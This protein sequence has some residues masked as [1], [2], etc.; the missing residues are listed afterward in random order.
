MEG[1]RQV[2]AVLLPWLAQGHIN[3]FLNLSKALASHGAV[4]LWIVSTPVNIS[5]IRA[6]LQ[7]E[8]IQLIEL[9]LPSVEGLAHGIERT[10]DIK[11]ESAHLLHRAFDQLDKPFEDL[12]RHLSPDVVI[13]DLPA[14]C[15][16]TVSANLG[17]PTLVFDVYSPTASSFVRSHSMHATNHGTKTPQDLTQPVPGFPSPFI[18]W[19]L[20]EAKASA[21]MFLP[22]P[23]GF[24]VTD[25]MSSA[26][27]QSSGILIK[28]CFQ[29]EEKY[30]QYLRESTGKPVISVGPLMLT[31]AEADAGV[32][33]YSTLNWL[34]KQVISSVVFV[35]F[36]SESFL[37]AAQITELA[38]ALEDSG[39][40]FLW[41]LRSS[42]GTSSLSLS[43]LPAGFESRTRDRGLVMGGWVPQI[44]IV[45]HPSVGCYV[46]HGGW[47]SVM[48]AWLYSGLPLVLIPLR[49]DQGLNCR[50]I[51]LEL[52]GGIE[53]VRDEEGGFSRENVCKAIGMVMGKDERG[54]AIRSRV[55]ELQ[56]VIR[57]NNARQ[58]AITQDLVNYLRT[59]LV[60]K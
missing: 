18:S 47:S 17:I 55:E 28:S 49:H 58:R 24:K 34:D 35:S 29:E 56:G 53:V 50:Q 60:K 16:A 4:K 5:G 32:E 11:P 36:G 20:F 9:K 8:P 37:S 44:S 15:A 46:T 33:D 52:N 26:Y 48:E 25:F 22:G 2:N 31:D 3:P 54:A 1:E 45:S 12:L 39:H 41:S 59:L 14:H 6:R 19:R 13:H 21:G 23:G 42:D 43:L 51:A 7:G 27:Q 40:P 30:L 10:A 38:F 57:L